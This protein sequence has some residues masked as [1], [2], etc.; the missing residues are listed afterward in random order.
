MLPIL[1][2]IFSSFWIWL[3]TFIL[4]A[5]ILEGTADIIRAARSPKRLKK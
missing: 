1:T 5:A 2:F 3:G 4:I